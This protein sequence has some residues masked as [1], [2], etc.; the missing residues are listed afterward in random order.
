[1]NPFEFQYSIL[2]YIFVFFFVYFLLSFYG[3]KTKK[4]GYLGLILVFF[5]INCI[6]YKFIGNLIISN[7]IY[8]E[9]HNIFINDGSSFLSK[10]EWIMIVLPTFVGLIFGLHSRKK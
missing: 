2:A 9:V 1:M 10:G 8:Y 7:P 4:Y 5:V 6:T 3:V